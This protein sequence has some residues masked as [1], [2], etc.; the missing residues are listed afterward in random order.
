VRWI[1][2]SLDALSTW[3]VFSQNIIDFILFSVYEDTDR[4]EMFNGL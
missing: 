4:G 3:S 1:L 2:A